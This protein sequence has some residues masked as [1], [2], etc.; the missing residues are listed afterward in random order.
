MAVWTSVGNIKDPS[1]GENECKI[2]K[3]AMMNEFFQWSDG[4][5]VSMGGGGDGF[6]FVLS[7][8]MNEGTSNCSATFEN[9]PLAVH[10]Y[11]HNSN[12]PFTVR[13]V[14]VW[15]FQPPAENTPRKK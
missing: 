12:G 8:D 2:Y 6:A 11:T 5:D 14:E 13:N 7:R 3:W 15:S 4:D 1:F 9:L 10:N